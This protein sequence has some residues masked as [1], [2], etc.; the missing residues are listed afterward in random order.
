MEK[1]VTI[2]KSKEGNT[3]NIISKMIGKA[4]ITIKMLCKLH[5]AFNTC[6]MFAVLVF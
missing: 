3:K 4:Y 5:K 6:L 2:L 1:N